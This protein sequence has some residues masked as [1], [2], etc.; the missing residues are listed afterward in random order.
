MK[1]LTFE[2]MEQINAG[3]WLSDAWNAVCDAVE[4]AWEWCKDHVFIRVSGG[5]VEAGVA[6]R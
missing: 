2:Q 4:T 5:T 3:G 6:L 1:T